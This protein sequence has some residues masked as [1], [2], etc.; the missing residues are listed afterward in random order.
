MTAVAT[1]P[2]SAAR[3]RSIWR[4]VGIPAEHGGWGLTLEPVLLGLVVAFSWS[5]LAIGLAAFLAFLVRTPLKLALVDRRR[6]RSLPRTQ[7]ATGLAIVE[8][9]VLGTVGAAAVAAAGV[10]WLVPVVCAVPFVAIELWFDV[11][12]RSRRLVPE[13][14][15]A[16]GIAAVAASIVIAGDGDERLAVA[17]W[18][19]LAARS[20]ASIPYVRTQIARTHSRTPSLGATDAFQLTGAVLALLAVVVDD[21]VLLGACIVALAALAQSIAMRRERIAPVKVIG[22]RQM[23]IGLAIVAATS[24][25]VLGS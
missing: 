24:A 17:A 14:C 23:A 13:V 10:G 2:N 25:G 22:L 3:V 21:R 16:V 12:S 18:M 9:A 20:V 4:T 19:I 8:L 1:A 11:R 5:G 15:G 6:H 7:L